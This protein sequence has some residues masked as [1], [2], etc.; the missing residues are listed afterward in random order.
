[1]QF[2][3]VPFSS[4]IPSTLAHAK[5][6]WWQAR[7]EYGK[8]IQRCHCSL[9]GHHQRTSLKAS[10]SSAKNCWDMH[11]KNLKKQWKVWKRIVESCNGTSRISWRWTKKPCWCILTASWFMVRLPAQ[12]D[13]HRSAN[14]VSL[15][16]SGWAPKPWISVQ[17]P[18]QSEYSFSTALLNKSQIT[19][20]FLLHTK[21]VCGN[22][23]DKNR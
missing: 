18:I 6:H 23:N 5:S 12:C 9:P 21:C 16:R 17:H 15:E 22:Q 7:S 4:C 2:N 8:S 1:M 10:C 11:Q 14:P 13:S 19:N 3:H 20:T